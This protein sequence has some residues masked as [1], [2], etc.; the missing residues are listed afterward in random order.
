MESTESIQKIWNACMD[1]A[2]ECALNQEEQD[3]NLPWQTLFF[4]NVAKKV[5]DFPKDIQQQL[6][7][8]MLSG[9]LDFFTYWFGDQYVINEKF[10]DDPDVLLF[11]RESEKLGNYYFLSLSF[12]FQGKNT[13]CIQYLKKFISGYEDTMDEKWFALHF[14]PFKNAYPGFWDTL[15]NILK[16]S[17]VDPQLLPLCDAA[18]AYYTTG[19]NAETVDTLCALLQENPDSALLNELLGF[20]YYRSNQWRNAAACF[21]KIENPYLCQQADFAFCMGWTYGKCREPLLEI[22]AYEKCVAL[23]ESVQYAMNNLGY[24]YYKVHQYQKALEIFEICLEKKLDLDYTVNN[25]VRTLLALGQYQ[26]AKQFAKNSPHKIAKYLLEKLQTKPDVNAKQAIPDAPER[27]EPVMQNARF[28][29]NTGT[30]FS[31]ERLLEEELEERMNKGLS[32]F[33]MN[34]K[35]YRRKGIYGRQFIIPEGRLDLLAEDADGNLYVIELKKD[36]GYDNAYEQ[37][38]RYL[39]SPTMQ[40][41]AGKKKLYGIICLNDPSDKLIRAVKKDARIRLFEYQI[42]YT[43]VK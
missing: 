7:Q 16:I 37:T 35:M 27:T 19:N 1:D 42:S 14:P 26:K 23:D 2:I 17:G 6:R 10:T 12:Y 3:S 31:S 20:A 40:K 34:L 21:E 4:S 9:I 13:K 39:D 24:A 8:E 41:L 18:K 43:E 33:G 5:E 22:E 32:V 28:Q 25:Y 29:A 30:Q 38:V 11:I 36:S 15:K